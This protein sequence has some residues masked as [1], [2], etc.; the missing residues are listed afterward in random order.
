MKASPPDDV[1]RRHLRAGYWGLSVFV[2]LGAALEAFHAQKAP[3]LLDAGQETTRMMLRLA[4]AH[5]TLIALVN[6]AYGLTVRVEERAAGPLP[7]A[8]LL[9][10]L[11]LLPVG[12]LLGGIG[13][14]GGDPGLGIALVPAGAL[15]M[16]VFAIGVGR[17]LSQRQ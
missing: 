13:A 4:H 11:V 8:S 9:A 17:R 15:G 2:V 3:W 14:R 12:F 1:A 10:A 16:L 6:V 5:G 7:S